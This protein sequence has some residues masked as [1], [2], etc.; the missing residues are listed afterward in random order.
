M[1]MDLNQDA[2]LQPV[3]QS[4]FKVLKHSMYFI[5]MLCLVYT[6]FIGIFNNKNKADIALI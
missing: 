4:A 3:S 1:I 6:L 5:G 2:K